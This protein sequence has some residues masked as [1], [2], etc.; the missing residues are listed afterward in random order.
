MFY[1]DIVIRFWPLLLMIAIATSLAISQLTKS[2]HE[3]RRGFE[4]KLS[5]DNPSM[6]QE[7][8]KERD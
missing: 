5:T 2:R 3:Q 1:D 8:Q 4:V 7:E 6:P